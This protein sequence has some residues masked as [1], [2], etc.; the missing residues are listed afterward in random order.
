VRREAC[1]D[2]DDEAFLTRVIR[3]AAEQDRLIDEVVVPESWF[4]RDPQVFEFLQR[5]AAV[6]AGP[7]HS[8]PMRILCVPCA[9]GQEPYSVAMALFAAGLSAHQFEIDAADVSRAALARAQDA[10]YSANSF[11]SADL[12]FQEQWFK[13]RGSAVELDPTVRQQVHFFQG[14]L[15]DESFAADRG[16]YDIIFCRNLL[17]YLTDDARRQTER[18]IDRLLKPAGLLVLGAAEPPILQGDWIPAALDAVFVMRRGSRATDSVSASLKQPPRSQYLA[19]AN[20]I[21][22]SARQGVQS[23]SPPAAPPL[24]GAAESGEA[25]PSTVANLLQAAAALAD[26]GHLATALALCER[27]QQAVGPDPQIFFLMGMLHYSARDLD[28]AEA[29]L[30][31]TLYLDANHDE[32]LLALAI[33]AEQRGDRRMADIYR[34][35]ATRVLAR[36]G[37]S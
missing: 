4:F 13:P 10:T 24:P 34:R 28:R 27:H 33:S 31:K 20:G 7:P 35:S 17:I 16:P 19:R 26:A 21:S 22:S 1:G 36:K 14:N 2:P 30:H 32:A 18:A 15:L 6:S 12:R 3:D 9:A 23:P 8:H 37:S 25:G 5:F 11:R 29:C